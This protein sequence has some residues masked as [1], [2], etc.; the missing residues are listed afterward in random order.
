MI[1]DHKNKKLVFV[2]SSLLWAQV[3]FYSEEPEKIILEH[4]KK[5]FIFMIADHKNKKKLLFVFSSLL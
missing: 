2:F 5:L 1:G 4:K 3:I